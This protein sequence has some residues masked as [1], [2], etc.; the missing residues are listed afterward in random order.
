MPKKKRQKVDGLSPDDIKKI[1]SAIRQV[2]SWSTPKRLCLVRTQHA[3]GF[4]RCELCKEK[5]PK[6]FVDHIVPVGDV[7]AGFIERLFCSSLGLQGL[8]KACHEAKT[9]EERATARRDKKSVLLGD[10]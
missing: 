8:C 4:S 7:D 6:V 5:T 10:W 3:D 2:W 9:R 1:R